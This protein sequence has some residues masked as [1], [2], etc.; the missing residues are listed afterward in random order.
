M[1]RPTIADVDET[2][3]GKGSL[4]GLCIH[5]PIPRLGFGKF[6]HSI[7]YIGEGRKLTLQ[8]PDR[9]QHLCKSRRNEMSQKK[10]ALKPVLCKS[11]ATSKDELKCKWFPRATLRPKCLE[12]S[13][14]WSPRYYVMILF[15]IRQSKFTYHCFCA[16]QIWWHR[17]ACPQQED[18]IW[19]A[20]I[21]TSNNAK[22]THP[23]V[24]HAILRVPPPAPRSCR[25]ILVAS[26]HNLNQYLRNTLRGPM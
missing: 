1:H 25:E 10:E 5:P 22:N 20:G 19:H 4:V 11:L 14:P 9:V 13:I 7:S 26:H 17:E 15:F 24:S 12:W 6:T 23:L 16:A 8:L 21:R 18:C 3:G 2:I